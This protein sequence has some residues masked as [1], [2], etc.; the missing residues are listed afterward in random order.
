METSIRRL[1]S[2]LRTARVAW[3]LGTTLVVVLLL[4]GIGSGRAEASFALGLQDDGFTPSGSQEQTAA[5]YSAMSFI[6]GSYVRIALEWE[7]VVGRTASFN[8]ADPADRQYSWT[9]IDDAVRSAAAH[10]LKA[11][12][13]IDRAPDWAIGPGPITTPISQGAWDP[14]PGM[15]SRFVHAAALRYSGSF[16]DPARPGA[17]LPRVRYWEAWNEPNIPGFFSAPNQV[18]AYRN[19]LDV[20][21]SQLKA[22]HRDNVVLLGGLSPVSSVQGSTPLLTFLADLL[23]VRRSGS[24]YVTIPSCRR[25]HFD[26]IAVHPYALAATPTKHAY[27]PGD[28]LI[29]DIG[30][31]PALIRATHRNYPL[32]VT[33]FSWF[34]NP[35]NAQVGDAPATAARYVD[36]SLYEMWKAGVAVVIWFTVLDGDHN[37]NFAGPG[38]FFAPAQPKPS[39]SAFAFPFVAGVGHG[40]GFG[41]GRV[42][43]SRPRKVVVERLKG[44]RWVGVA[45]TRTGPDG[46]FY[47]HF[48]ARQNGLYRAVVSGGPTSLEYDSRPI[49]PRRTHLYQIA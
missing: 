9:R 37:D 41:W 13:V 31:L 29:G 33:E 7:Q 3:A 43:T 23:C 1:T 46:V 49:P 20:A 30:V 35:P 27:K 8:Q 10:R 26:A 24:R 17:A 21:F 15:Y 12:F 45:S 39:L 11:I 18:A 44:R 2:R 4:L 36:Y 34:T 25:A 19:I 5:A 40:S 28:L 47:V 32:W 42:P 48:G 22:V 38:L 16:P 6:H 14:N